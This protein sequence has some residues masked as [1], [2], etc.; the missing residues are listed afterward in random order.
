L[1]RAGAGRRVGRWGTKLSRAAVAESGFPGYDLTTWWGL[2]GPAGLSAEVVRRVHAD[3]LAA[4]AIPDVRERFASLSVDPGG[5]SSEEFAAY[6]RRE[7]EKYARLV[8]QLD[9]KAD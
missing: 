8:K 3:T 5:G 4:L 6:V 1:R 9:I 2:F 7:V